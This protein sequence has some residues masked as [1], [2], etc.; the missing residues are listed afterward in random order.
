[1]D[2]LRRLI[3][4][5]ILLM[6]GSIVRAQQQVFVPSCTGVAATDTATFTTIKTAVGSTNPVTIQLPYKS[7]ITKRCKLNAIT[8]T[9]NISLDGTNGE[10]AV[11]TGQTLTVQGPVIAPARLLFVNATSGLGTVSFSGNKSLGQ[12]LP[13]WWG[14]VADGSTDMLAAATAALVAG[15]GH[16]IHFVAGNYLTSNSLVVAANTLITGDGD[17]TKITCPANGWDLSVGTIHYGIFVIKNV[18]KVRISNL[19]IYGTKTA[20]IDGSCDGGFPRNCH[21]PK[22]IYFEGTG[23][24]SVMDGSMVDHCWIENSAWEGIWQ[25]GS[26][27]STID[28]QITNNQ[29]KDI[30][31]PSAVTGNFERAVVSDNIFINC[32]FGIGVLGQ[33]ITITGNVVLGAQ[34]GIAAG[35]LLPNVPTGFTTITGNTVHIVPVG[36]NGYSGITI[37]NSSVSPSTLNVVTGNSV[38]I[39]NPTGA[40][41]AGGAIWIHNNG[42]NAEIN[43]N[44]INIDGAGFG[45]VF[46]SS[47]ADGKVTFRD[48]TVRVTNELGPNKVVAF[49]GGPD[50]PGHAATVYSFNNR[51]EGVTLAN[52]N[53][54]FEYQAQ[55]GGTLTAYLMGDTKDG[56]QIILGGMSSTGASLN[57]VPL[58]MSSAG[59]QDSYTAQAVLGMLRFTSARSFTIA[60]GVI[61][62]AS[63]TNQIPLRQTRILVDTEGSAASDDLDTINGG[64]DGDV[65]I[66][67]SVASTRDPTVKNL[68]GNINIGG[69]QTLGTTADRLALVYSGTLS[70]WVRWSNVPSPITASSN[71]FLTGLGADGVF[72]RTQPTF[73]NLATGTAPAFT[74]G[75]T[76]SGG[77]QQLNNVIIGASTPLAITGT[78][79]TASTMFSGPHNGTLGATTPASAV[80]TTLS[81]SGTTTPTGGIAAAGGFSIS[82]RLIASC[83][84]PAITATQ[85]TDSAPVNTETYIVEIFIPA[86][87][88][89]TG[90]AL[91][92]GSAVAGNVKISLADSTGAPIAAAVTASTAQA[93]TAVYQL[94]PFA[95][96]YAAKGPATYYVLVQFNTNTTPRF[97]T[98][99]VGVCGASKKTGETYGTFT[100]VTPPTT[101]T[102]ALGPTVSLY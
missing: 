10:I 27:P 32:I 25:G 92:N 78:T 18:S 62:I 38:F 76:V 66:L 50:G 74:L 22:L 19:R 64:Q 86:N 1:M 5:L 81:A 63:V 48:N 100:S 36:L 26:I 72:T 7:D 35:E 43:S 57:N 61:N 97:R 13:Q 94:I 55:F 28:I 11:V 101:F 37:S 68:T 83:G 30:D 14:V 73:S 90:V 65:V 80:V 58:F 52:S 99:I 15:A 67:G 96:A 53:Y 85:G 82:P 4:V 8:L 6:A 60:T 46:S 29:F 69:D 93:G 77:G 91:L 31:G 51:V 71:N 21:T 34:Q 2:T 59:A 16:H 102:T 42:T 75:G 23:G 98:H 44:T 89:V 45:A 12:I 87:T 9:S 88:T 84:T 33:Y 3:A 40:G 24:A 17:A 20:P 47:I 54:A 56:G 41:G 95:V 70:Q 39:D 79:I 49:F